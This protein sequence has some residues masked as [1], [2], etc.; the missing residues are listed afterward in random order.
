MAMSK[1]GDVARP[2]HG[3]RLGDSIRPSVQLLPVRTARE[4]PTTEFAES[5]QWHGNNDNNDKK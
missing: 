3:G 2:G 4:G 5:L 1:C